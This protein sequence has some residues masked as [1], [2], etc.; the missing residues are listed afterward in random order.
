[1]W[2]ND[3]NDVKIEWYKIL[4]S[5]LQRLGG[6]P[7][8]IRVQA[9]DPRYCL[10]AGVKAGLG[11]CDL[12][13]WETFLLES[14]WISMLVGTEKLIVCCFL[15]FY[16]YS[17]FRLNSGTPYF[18]TLG[19][20]SSLIPTSCRCSMPPCWDASAGRGSRWDVEQAA[21]SWWATGSLMINHL[22]KP[23]RIY[24]RMKVGRCW[25]VHNKFQRW[26][27]DDGI[28]FLKKVCDP[29][30][31]HLRIRDASLVTPCSALFLRRSS[32]SIAWWRTG[33]LH[34][35][36]MWWLHYLGCWWHNVHSLAV[37]FLNAQPQI[38][39]IIL[40]YWIF[41]HIFEYSCLFPIFQTIPTK[42]I[43][44]MSQN[45]TI[46]RWMES[47]I[48]AVY[49]S[50]RLVPLV[51]EA[52]Q[53]DSL[54]TGLSPLTVDWPKVGP[55]I[56]KTSHVQG[57]GRVCMSVVSPFPP[58][59]LPKKKQDQLERFI[60]K[61]FTFSNHTKKLTKER[62]TDPWS[63][64]VA[65]Q[66]RNTWGLDITV[67]EIKIE[68]WWDWDVPHPKTNMSHLKIG[69]WEATFLLGRP[70]FRGYVSFRVD[71]CW[72]HFLAKLSVLNLCSFRRRVKMV[73]Q[74]W[75]SRTIAPTMWW[76]WR[77]VWILQH[78]MDWIVT[79]LHCNVM[80]LSISLDR[81]VQSRLGYCRLM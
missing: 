52:S 6:L 80:Y 37:E 57:P 7:S 27:G 30:L 53:I 67:P 71:I 59:T 4:L 29:S 43:C 48:Q 63:L 41:F 47:L 23:I 69:V 28:E 13:R 64:E 68:N 19:S 75:P 55:D 40:I 76:C 8:T 15:F 79:F 74:S 45:R 70:I 1:M 5:S 72:W 51:S 78:W 16:G 54:R 10:V 50:Q 73:W 49:W 26:D 36:K 61:T 81:M 24:F 44:H 58:P 25:N 62:L 42:T 38:A 9:T 3:V 20:S 60:P 66:K 21:D 11:C 39:W 35:P 14:C 12:V 17:G 65:M 22:V 34:D 77:L 33:W 46:N 31:I 56:S 18:Y 2:N 32:R